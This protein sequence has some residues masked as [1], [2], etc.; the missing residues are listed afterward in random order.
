MS[1]QGEPVAVAAAPLLTYAKSEPRTGHLPRWVPWFAAIWAGLAVANG[2]FDLASHE[3]YKP[4]GG[5][6]WWGRMA[7]AC[8][9]A[10]EFG[11]GIIVIFALLMGRER[12]ALWLQY[13]LA[14]IA[15]G[16]TVGPLCYWLCDLW[17]QFQG[18]TLW[19]NRSAIALFAFFAL[20]Q[21]IARAAL[22]ALLLVLLLAP[23]ENGARYTLRL[24]RVLLLAWAVLALCVFGIA[25]HERFF[26]S[27]F[28][29]S[30]VF[31]LFVAGCTIT[32]LALSLAPDPIAV[33]VGWFVL[34]ASVLVTFFWSLDFN[35][36]EEINAAFM[37][38]LSV[39][40]AAVATLLLYRDLRKPR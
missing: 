28:E 26:E 34:S 18:P 17:P 21:A 30:P 23:P 3:S 4:S 33:P 1:E 32:A 14:P 2:V 24:G 20:L 8:G 22:P 38:M 19:F 13:S 10:A 39:P 16:T 37:L 5:L 40:L 29:E 31:F 27:S 12:C 6:E 7:L 11:A 36:Q 35:E 9:I 15:L 25:Y